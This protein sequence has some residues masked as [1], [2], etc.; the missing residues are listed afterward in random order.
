M[1]NAALNGELENTLYRRDPNFGLDVP[2]RIEDVDSKLLNPRGTWAD[3]KAYDLQ[4][5]KLVQMFIK[6]FAKFETHVTKDII[7]AAPQAA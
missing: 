7:E 5:D 6:N 4:A 3:G 1:L 2:V